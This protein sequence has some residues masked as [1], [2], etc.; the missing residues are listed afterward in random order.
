MA[1]QQRQLDPANKSQVSAARELIAAAARVD[2]TPAISDQALISALAGHRALFAYFDDTT[3]VPSTAIAV[4][5]IGEAELDLVVHPARRGAGYG[6]A[7]LALLLREAKPSDTEGLRAWVHGEQAAATHLLR[8]T[9]FTPERT[10]YRMAL[11]PALLPQ[12]I[13]DARPL[14]QGFRTRTFDPLNP[15]DAESW[16]QVNAAAF[17][18]HPEQGSVT[19]GDF[20]QLRAEPWFDPADLIFAIDEDS[21]A[22]VGF[23]WVKTL[24]GDGATENGQATE[25]ELYVLGVDPGH[26][27]SGLGAALL[28]VTLSRMQMHQPSRITLYVDGSNTRARALYQRAG[29]IDDTVSTQWHRNNG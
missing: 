28:G 29:F 7:A 2:G 26:A 19:L 3:A 8:K 5:V 18:D 16:V 10:L 22:V 21:D 1:L 6:S 17:A 20:A 27:G 15:H 13:A 9:G 4:G 24:R 11:D 23:T 12:A 25:T 14:P